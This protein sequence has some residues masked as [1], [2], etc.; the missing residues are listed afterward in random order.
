MVWNYFIENVKYFRRVLEY[1]L[2]YLVSTRVANYSDSTAVL[3]SDIMRCED[4]T[5]PTVALSTRL[6]P[7]SLRLCLR[8]SFSSFLLSGPPHGLYFRP[9]IHCN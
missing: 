4:I 7:S 2:R 3:F 6:T 1:S 5:S 8:P 9:T